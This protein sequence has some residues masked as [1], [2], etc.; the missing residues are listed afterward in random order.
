MKVINEKSSEAIQEVGGSG[1]II[2][3]GMSCGAI[4]LLA[5]GVAAAFAA[6]SAAV[7]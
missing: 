1:Q 4:C 5:G 2:V 7:Y 6:I 3:C